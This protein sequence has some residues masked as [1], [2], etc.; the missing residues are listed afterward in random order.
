MTLSYKIICIAT[1]QKTPPVLSGKHWREIRSIESVL[2]FLINIYLFEVIVNS[3]LNTSLS[4][5]GRRLPLPECFFTGIHYKIPRQES[6]HGL[7]SRPQ[8]HIRFLGSLSGPYL[9]FIE[10]RDRG[11]F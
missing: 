6:S 4:H 2:R 8:L 11:N 5:S 7:D 1:E 3:C 9:G 10:R